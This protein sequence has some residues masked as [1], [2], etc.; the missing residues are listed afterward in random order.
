[1]LQAVARQERERQATKQHSADGQGTEQREKA[2]LDL[3]LQVRQLDFSFCSR[4][5]AADAASAVV[6]NVPPAVAR[7]SAPPMEIIAKQE[8]EERKVERKASKKHSV[9]PEC[10][11][12]ISNCN[13][14]SPHLQKAF[15]SRFVLMRWC[16]P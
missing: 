9:A 2:W 3:H 12:C 13:N 15:S 6:Q 1:M 11:V 16:L 10:P 5:S 8:E 4:I 14:F 7:P